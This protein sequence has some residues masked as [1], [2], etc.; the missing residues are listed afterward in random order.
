MED[1][2]KRL[3][4][5][6]TRAENVVR[7]ADEER[8]RLVR[9]ALDEAKAAEKRLDKRLPDMRQAFL[10]KAEAQAEQNLAELERRYQ[11]RHLALRQAAEAKESQALD[12]ALKVL[13]DPRQQ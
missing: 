10:D 3:L 1:V 7:E 4:G 11:E 13:L 5:A 6:E 9:Q 8:E 12:A 2:L